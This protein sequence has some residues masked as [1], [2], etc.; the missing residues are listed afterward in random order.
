MTKPPIIGERHAL[1]IM[2]TTIFAMTPEADPPAPK[3]STTPTN[4]NEAKGRIV[5]SLHDK[6]INEAMD[7]SLFA[8]NVSLG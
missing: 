7:N 8:Q 4:R 6:R 1:T 2:G 5:Q 3:M